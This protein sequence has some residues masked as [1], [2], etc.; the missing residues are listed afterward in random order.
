MLHA[1]Q[2]CKMICNK[3][4]EVILTR[5]TSTDKALSATVR[6]SSSSRALPLW[7][8]EGWLSL[9]WPDWIPW[10]RLR[11]EWGLQ[12]D[13]LLP[14][15]RS[16]MAS[17]EMGGMSKSENFLKSSLCFDKGLEKSSC[18][19]QI[20]SFACLGGGENKWLINSK[21]YFLL[22]GKRNKTDTKRLSI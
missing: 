20:P 1:W 13:R 16:L 18:F 5:R 2:S 12:L 4:L 22:N 19:F 9:C 3:K 7:G 21:Q 14:P 6:R 8:T 17:G 10:L 15:P 11:L